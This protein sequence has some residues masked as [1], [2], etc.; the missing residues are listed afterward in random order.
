VEPTPP[1]VEPTPPPVEPTPPPVEPTP[2]PTECPP[3]GTI[4]QQCNYTGTPECPGGFEIVYQEA[5][6]ACGWYTIQTGGCC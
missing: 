3:A 1:P 2:P 4:R 5:D 6:G